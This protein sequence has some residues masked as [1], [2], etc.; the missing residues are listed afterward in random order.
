[1]SQYYTGC[2]S[3]RQSRP[4]VAAA[5]GS[6]GGS[7][8]HPTNGH[9]NVI[10][11][12][13]TRD[14][15]QRPP[16]LDHYPQPQSTHAVGQVVARAYEGSTVAMQPAYVPSQRNSVY[17]LPLLYDPDPSWAWVMDGTDYRPKLGDRAKYPPYT[18]TLSAV[19][20]HEDRN[21]TRDLVKA[22]F[23]LAAS[24]LF[25][26][27][28]YYGDVVITNAYL[29]KE[30]RRHQAIYTRGMGRSGPLTLE[31]VLVEVLR[32]QR[33]WFHETVDSHECHP[34]S[35]DASIKDDI[36]AAWLEDPRA[37]RI[38]IVQIRRTYPDCNGRVYVFPQL[39]LYR[40]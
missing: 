29:T 25:F 36:Y 24:M 10:A 18:L 23:P 8:R 40:P 37:D 38:S 11:P 15:L 6:Y 14:Y 32:K 19:E 30:C 34:L 2:T 27:Q 35:P 21:Q 33:Q 20:T 31:D 13:P 4:T 7:S 3:Q 39:E 5:G 26:P 17:R 16:L 28:G 22:W 9:K 12:T 1:M